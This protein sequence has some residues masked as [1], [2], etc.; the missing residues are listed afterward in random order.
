MGVTSREVDFLEK[1]VIIDRHKQLIHNQSSNGTN[2]QTTAH[3]LYLCRRKRGNMAEREPR[4]SYE[5]YRSERAIYT[6]LYFPKRIDY[7]PAI[8]NA[9]RQ[10]L[11]ERTVKA[12][13]REYLPRLMQEMW[14]YPELF[15]PR[16]YTRTTP[17]TAAITEAQARRRVAQ[18]RLP[19][20]GWSRYTVEGVFRARRGRRRISE[21]LTQAVRIIF[22]LD[23][24][25]RDE[26]DRAGCLDVL[27]LMLA[28]IITDDLRLG[29]QRLW[30]P[31][32]IQRFLARYEPWPEHK[33]AFVER[34][35]DSVAKEVQK[36][37][38]DC[39]L[40]LFGFLIRKFWV[41]IGE[42]HFQ[43]DEI[44]AGSFFNLGLNVVR[45]ERR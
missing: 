5:F 39:A 6:E 15:D 43:E 21:E 24:R 9:L 16:Q 22:R 33:R 32:E 40:Y 36:W 17:R 23:S 26:A 38:D 14:R 7:E 4:L 37:I 8:A 1:R 12:Y 3:I 27:R 25:Y 35:F 19:V 45:Q 29:E 18:F 34:Y 41:S 2:G 31:Q 11:N 20:E 42:E 30:D 10:G 28:W 44:W 13:F